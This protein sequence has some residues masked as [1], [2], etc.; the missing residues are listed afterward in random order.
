MFLGF[1]T[2]ALSLVA[3]DWPG[4]WHVQK[5]SSE[6]GLPQNNVRAVLQSRSG[7]LWVGTLM[8]LARFDGMNF[9]VFTH[10]DTPGL[11]SDTI[12]ALAEDESGALWVGTQKGLIQ[13]ENGVS[14][15][16]NTN[17]GFPFAGNG[18]QQLQVHPKGGIWF[19]QGNAV[20]LFKDG[21]AKLY[22]KADGLGA[23]SGRRFYS[24]LKGG[25]LM[26][27]RTGL[28]RLEPDDVRFSALLPWP[29][30][31]DFWC[32]LEDDHGVLWA[33]SEAGLFRLEHNKWE[34]QSARYGV[35][36]QW[37][38]RLLQF[39]SGTIWLATK[40]KGLQFLNLNRR[41][42]ESVPLPGGHWHDVG[43]MC[44]DE[45][46]NVWVGTG[47][48][49]LL[50]LR[51]TKIRSWGQADGLPHDDVRTL[52]AAPDGTIWIGSE[53][54]LARIRNNRVEAF[55]RSRPEPRQRIGAIGVDANGT[56]WVSKHG[57][58]RGLFRF[59]GKD[60]QRVEHPALPTNS[61]HSIHSFHLDRAGRF[62]IAGRGSVNYISNGVFGPK[63]SS[64]EFKAEASALWFDRREHL[65]VGVAGFGLK[66]C[67]EGKV[68]SLTSRDGLCDDRPISI[69]EDADG[70]L[71]VGSESGLSRI[72][73]G[74]VTALRTQD[75]LVENVINQ[76]LEDQYGYFWL[77]GLRG[78]HRVRRADLNARAEGRIARVHCLE[79]GE[80]DGMASSETNGERQPCG[81]RTADGRLWFASMGGVVE[82][83]PKLLVP[84]EKIP[85]V[86]IEQ[87]E[88][89]NG[90]AFKPGI[91]SQP[92]AAGLLQLP[93]GSGRLI[94]LH[95]S[96]PSLT[97][98][99]QIR[100]QHRLEPAYTGWHDAGEER[101]AFYTGL[102]PGKYRFQVR[103]SNPHGVW[104][105]EPTT[106][107]FTLA[108]RFYERRS[109]QVAAGVLL[110]LVG[111]AVH[112]WRIHVIRRLEKL[113]RDQALIVERARIAEDLHDDLGANLTG[114]ALKAELTRRQQLLPDQLARHLSDLVTTARGL[115]DS[116]R[117]AIW[118]ANPRH[119]TLESLASQLARQTE[120]L[121]TDAGLRVRLD[122]PPALPNLRVSSRAR[123]QLCLAVKEALHN[124]VKH[125]DAREIRLGLTLSP[126]ELELS[127]SD[128]GRGLVQPVNGEGQ[129]VGNM[130]E[131]LARLDGAVAWDPVP[132]SG[133]RVLFRIPLQSLNSLPPAS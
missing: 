85:R 59:D 40:E 107:A 94:G 27:S 102:R 89:V 125:A 8:G 49:G 47:G 128:D 121:A 90:L 31:S 52:C 92:W 61:T 16:W 57:E 39:H 73:D 43:C 110:L 91:P 101:T 66:R 9:R 88:S 36:G 114:L 99:E 65:W 63:I 84:D 82:I 108:P 41:R 25:I 126:T 79:Y 14:K 76:I 51:P 2:S 22:G 103:A 115:S 45:E 33:G 42:F 93:P 109:L 19:R 29:A 127:V 12:C 124:A 67:Y 72:K 18:V 60:Y 95:Y 17:H 6:H 70:T 78:I 83:D 34:P 35:Q 21:Q 123:H 28:Q 104:R 106:F 86:T 122:L 23:E 113:E 112:Q 133:T 15:L 120:S 118:L 46:G 37:V 130:R 54:G 13:W 77:G 58:G 105:E 30:P 10:T 44:Q 48:G 24:T 98:A 1:A 56:V 53:L 87:V 26:S 71:W 64:P 74:R 119:D 3:E 38:T 131:R 62:W 55:P 68:Q 75:G 69:Y 129:G 96:A 111:L 50:R 117:E 81:G 32:V 11:V 100:F 116:M 4:G 20:G 97:A 80:P 7:Y 5:W 132:D